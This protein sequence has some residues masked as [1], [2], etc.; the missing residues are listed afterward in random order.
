MLTEIIIAIVALLGMAGAGFGA[1]AMGK[2]EGR[3]DAE[4]QHEIEERNRRIA[5]RQ[6]M[7]EVNLGDDPAVLRDWL[8][9]RPTDQR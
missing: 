1:W 8:R 4:T 5:T 3:K 6:R 9:N 7:E 2:R